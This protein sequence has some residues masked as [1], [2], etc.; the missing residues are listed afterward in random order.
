LAHYLR[1]LAS[2]FHVWYNGHKILIDD[3][4]VRNARLALSV[5]VRDVIAHGLDILG[6]NAPDS[7]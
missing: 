5:A 7:M 3:A 4:A 2:D 1:D 6:V